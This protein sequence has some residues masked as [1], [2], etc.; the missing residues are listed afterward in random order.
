MSGGTSSSESETWFSAHPPAPSQEQGVSVDKSC[1]NV[2]WFV[3]LCCKE[4]R[5]VRN[6]CD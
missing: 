3:V 4:C 1:G 2:L 6:P 5:E